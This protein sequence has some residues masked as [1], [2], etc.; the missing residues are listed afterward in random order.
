MHRAAPP[1]Q[2]SSPKMP[3]MLRLINPLLEAEQDNFLQAW[4]LH[5]S[6]R[7]KQG[8]TYNLNI[9]VTDKE[10]EKKRIIKGECRSRVSV[11]L[12]PK[13]VEA[14]GWLSKGVSP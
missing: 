11:L 9:S 2:L 3:I 14:G 8:N 10:K 4:G 5:S 1:Q 13:G 12:Y 6:G 7:D